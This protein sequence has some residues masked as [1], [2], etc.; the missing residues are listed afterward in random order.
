MKSLPAILGLMVM[1]AVPGAA[2][3]K[4]QT[5]TLKVDNMFCASC[6]Y[7]V[8]RAL[9][10]VNGVDRVTVSFTDKTA[11]VVYDDAKTN[12]ETLTAATGKY[13]FPSTV[14]A[15]NDGS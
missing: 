1:L 6:P 14:V 5:A 12:V 4:E 7:I 13:G 11:V 9:T 8:Q 15:K 2:R 10:S 3:A